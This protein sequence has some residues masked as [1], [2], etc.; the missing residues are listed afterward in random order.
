MERLQQSYQ[1]STYFDFLRIESTNW[2]EK[3][4]FFERRYEDIGDLEYKDQIEI[5]YEYVKACYELENYH[6]Y[7]AL[8]DQLITAIFK[9]NISQINDVDIFQSL[10]YMKGRSF[11]HLNDLDNSDYIFSELVK[12]DPYNH[13]YKKM[14]LANSIQKGVDIPNKVV[15]LSVA[16]IIVFLTLSIGDL[17]L[18]GPFYKQWTTTISTMKITTLILSF[19]LPLAIFMKE[20]LGGHFRLYQLLKYSKN[21]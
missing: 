20:Y 18:V 14:Y 5:W 11:K 21:K 7:I 16:F 3:V 9:Y 19:M 6:Q 10:L 12:I 8:S 15:I 1:R 17:L 2:K 4:R 13:E